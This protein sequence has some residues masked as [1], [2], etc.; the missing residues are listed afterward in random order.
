MVY[1]NLLDVS[2]REAVLG[3]FKSIDPTLATW[4]KANSLKWYTEYQDTEVRSF[5]VHPD[6]KGRVQIAVDAPHHEQT[7]VRVGQYP[8]GLSRLRRT[9]DYPTPISALSETLDRALETAKAWLS[10]DVS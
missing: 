8:R 7:V 3:Q 9:M 6:S 10:D 5:F 1:A 2:M 4:A